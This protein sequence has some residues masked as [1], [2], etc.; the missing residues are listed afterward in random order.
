VKVVDRNTLRVI[1]AAAALLEMEAAN[2]LAF[3][4]AGY[5]AWDV[6]VR[7]GDDGV[8]RYRAIFPFGEGDIVLVP[9]DKL[10]R[11]RVAPTFTPSQVEEF[12]AMHA[13]AAT[14]EIDPNW[15]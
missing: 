14:I 7:A 2:V 15:A 4:S 12:K 11:E 8:M 10:P 1:A 9:L 5:S 6:C 13:R 3:P